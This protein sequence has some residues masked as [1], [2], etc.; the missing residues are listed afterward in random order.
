MNHDA[1]RVCTRCGGPGHEPE[2]CLNPIRCERCNKEGHVA[3][4]CTEK[5]PWEFSAPFFGLSAYGQGFHF[6]KS[7][8]SDDG[9]KDMSNIALITITQG[10]VSAKQIESEF[11][12][13][14]GPESTWGWYAQKW[15]RINIS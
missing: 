12:L 6:I 7:T 15:Q 4:V 13:K 9:I 3:R 1:P 10:V 14:A 8:T 5:M 2:A 11:R